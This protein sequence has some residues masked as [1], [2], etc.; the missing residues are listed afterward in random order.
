MP[1][2]PSFNTAP[3]LGLM[4][5]A[6]CLW[7]GKVFY[8]VGKMMLM[9]CFVSIILENKVMVMERWVELK[10]VSIGGCD[11]TPSIILFSH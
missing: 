9:A 8:D 5:S 3:F 7:L 1:P 4:F 6:V 11:H 2:T 10:E